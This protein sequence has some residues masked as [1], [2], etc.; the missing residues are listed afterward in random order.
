[1]FSTFPA[2]RRLAVAALSLALF[3]GAC[4]DSTGPNDDHDHEEPAGLLATLGGQQVVRVQPNRDVIGSFT[5]AVGE[6]TDHITIRF[7]AEDGD[8]LTPD[9][10]EYYL[11]AEVANGAIAEIEQDEP[12]EFGIH[13]HGKQVG[14]TT[15]RLKLM[16]G[17]VGSGHSDY[18]SPPITITVTN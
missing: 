6:E 12:G 3:T 11:A 15:V 4:S 10:D 13:V 5:V 8:V 1:M 14:T 7:L 9:E 18:T 2:P 17:S 16:H